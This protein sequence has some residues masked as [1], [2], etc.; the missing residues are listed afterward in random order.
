ME[1]WLKIDQQKEAT[2]YRH[3]VDL[4]RS[5]GADNLW[6]VACQLADELTKWNTFKLFSRR[7]VLDW[8]ALSA[9]APPRRE[10]KMGR[11]ISHSRCVR[12]ISFNKIAPGADH[13]RGVWL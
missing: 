6:W 3:I 11:R 9:L 5:E 10:W 2:A 12:H 4:M 1:R 7:K 13:H 8:V